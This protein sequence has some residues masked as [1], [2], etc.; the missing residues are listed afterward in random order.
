L[1][2][3][4]NGNVG[5]L[6]IKRKVTL[7]FHD[8]SW[9]LNYNSIQQRLPCAYRKKYQGSKTGAPWIVLFVVVVENSKLNESLSTW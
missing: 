5:K 2:C 9:Q 1:F 8:I 6:D 7:D 4:I 3:P